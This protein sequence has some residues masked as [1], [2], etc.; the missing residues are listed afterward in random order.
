M[1]KTFYKPPGVR[2]FS[3]LAHVTSTGIAWYIAT[4]FCLTRFVLPHSLFGA[5]ANEGYDEF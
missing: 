1:T 4:F 5:Y 3:F 2:F